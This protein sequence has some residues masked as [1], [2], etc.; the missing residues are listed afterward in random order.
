MNSCNNLRN[1][2]N[3]R[4]IRI[5]NYNPIVKNLMLINKEYFDTKLDSIMNHKSGRKESKIP[6]NLYHE[7]DR[8][9]VGN[10]MFNGIEELIYDIRKT[11]KEYKSAIKKGTY[12]STY[13]GNYF[14]CEEP[15]K[16]SDR[17]N[18]IYNIKIIDY[19]DCALP[20]DSLCKFNSIYSLHD[21]LPGTNSYG[22]PRSLKKIPIQET[23]WKRDCELFVLK[24]ECDFQEKKNLTYPIFDILKNKKI[25]PFYVVLTKNVAIGSSNNYRDT[26]PK[27]ASMYILHPEF[28]DYENTLYNLF[29]SFLDK[30]KSRPESYIP[31][32]RMYLCGKYSPQIMSTSCNPVDKSLSNFGDLTYIKTKGNY[33]HYAFYSEIYKTN[34]LVKLNIKNPVKIKVQR[35]KS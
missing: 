15:L 26:S 17:Q 29:H 30:H 19:T 8:S 33:L 2:T 35:L 9:I 27:Y 32:L 25:A 10:Q 18:L 21:F 16:S 7:I 13:L 3:I 20:K 23:T 11:K 24:V 34:M 14:S 4:E 22:I 12:V 28:Y 1:V 6:K 31:F 5:A